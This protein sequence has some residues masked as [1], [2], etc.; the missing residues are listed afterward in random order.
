[1]RA[2]RNLA[3]GGT[4]LSLCLA[5]VACK[6]VPEAESPGA[7]G[8]SVEQLPIERFDV[9]PAG[10]RP[11][12]PWQAVGKFSDLV[13]MDLR[14]DGE[15]SFIGNSVTGKGLVM[16]DRDTSAG[17]GC[18]IGYAFAPPPPGP[19]YLGFD[20]RNAPGS[21][22]DW[23]CRLSDSAG[24]GLLLRISPGGELQAGEIG[25]ALKSVGP[26]RPGVWYHAAIGFSGSGK[27]TVTLTEG[28]KP[29]VA[30]ASATIS[31][32]DKHLAFT[33]LIFRN[34]GSQDQTGGWALD[35]VLMAG[36]VDAPRKALLPFQQAPI[37]AL[38][39][40]PRKVYAY[41]YEIY[42]SGYSDKD[43][44]LA[45]YTRKLFNP[46]LTPADRVKAGTELL[47]RPLP[48][49]PM[50]AGLSSDEVLIRA[51]EEEV[52]LGIQMG[53]DG[54][55]LDF[56]ALPESYPDVENI[57]EYN[58]R[59]FALMDAAARVDP[60]FKIIPAIYAG[61]KPPPGLPPDQDVE[62][63]WTAAYADSPIV[64]K[65]LA[66]PQVLRTDDGRVY[67]SKW[68][69]EMYSAA[70]WQRVVDRL[71]ASGIPVAF[72][73][74]FNGLS[75]ARLQTYSSLCYAMADWGP[76][77]P[78]DYRWVEKARPLTTKVV[79][80][81]AFQ[82]VRT[83]ERV[84]WEAGGSEAFR[85]MWQSA[86]RDGADWVFI[87]TWSDYSE[88]AQAPSTAI[89]FALYDLN[90]YYIQW[91]K[92]GTPPVIDRDVLY[93]FHR[94][95]HTDTTSLRGEPWK[96]VSE[97][98]MTTRNDIELLAFLREPG[99]LRIQAGSEIRTEMAGAGITSLKAPF[100]PGTALTPLFSLLRNGRPVLEG[101]SRYAILDRLEY[102]NLLYHA[103]ILTND[104]P[105]QLP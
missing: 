14:A 82:D 96:L 9:Y 69:T 60:G 72:L 88:Q 25:G 29:G 103:G 4:A 47:Y 13:R 38:R 11:P 73:G 54:F 97:G 100:P 39:A 42:P 68:G 8:F 30:A 43:P 62:A 21:A 65:I 27:A 46:S 83:R 99:E 75:T 16:E 52:R 78:K 70:W 50:E 80:P 17:G 10:T 91:F 5:T 92:L 31:L 74:Q 1:M 3:L 22:L 102:P 26:V 63:A 34:F 84:Y 48:R 85:N 71:A 66:H 61:P 12:Y 77:T 64:R 56:F 94:I 24:R 28:A 7:A 44:G 57:R 15:S 59:S 36:K 19:L 53:L 89:G 87:T 81:V 41:Y 67:L 51:M 93:Y 98:N 105:L 6:R 104:E 58:R 76:R 32:S 20:F 2:L 40:S 18:G 55:L 49:P 37:S 101:R 23:E 90:A 95:Q 33:R 86:I 45:P 79:S 35:N